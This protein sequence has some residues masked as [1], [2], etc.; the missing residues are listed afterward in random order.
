MAEEDEAPRV[1]TRLDSILGRLRRVETQVNRLVESQAVEAKHFVVMDERGQPRAGSSWR[2][3]PQVGF[4]DSTGR[5]R[6]RVGQ[7]T[8]GTPKTLAKALGVNVG[9]TAGRAEACYAQ[10]QCEPDQDS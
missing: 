6:M 7:R 1:T 2:H 4:F 3:S 10:T 9:G 8:D 5:E